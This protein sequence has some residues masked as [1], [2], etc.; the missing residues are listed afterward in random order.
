MRIQTVEIVV[1]FDKQH[2]IKIESEEDWLI[3]LHIDGENCGVIHCPSPRPTIG[4]LGYNVT[5]EHIKASYEPWA[6]RIMY[7]LRERCGNL[8]EKQEEVLYDV[9]QHNLMYM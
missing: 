5:P 8:D 9:L 4:Q 6:E 2:I 1:Y 3:S 7:Y